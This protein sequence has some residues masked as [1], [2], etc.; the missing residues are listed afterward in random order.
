MEDLGFGG[1]LIVVAILL[2]G[3]A[4]EVF[5]GA[6]GLQVIAFVVVA[7]LLFVAVISI[8]QHFK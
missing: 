7:A 2:A 5:K 4:L 8:R 3:F 1:C 6:I